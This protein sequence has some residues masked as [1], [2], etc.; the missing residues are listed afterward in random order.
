VRYQDRV[1]L[2]GEEVL[3]HVSPH[4]STIARPVVLLFVVVAVASFG[5][6]ATPPGV[7]QGTVRAV[8]VAVAAGVLLLWVAR[9]LWR[10]RT[11]SFLVTGERLLLRRGF[12]ARCTESV[13]LASVV[14]VTSV[15]SA[16]DRMT[17]AGTLLV[18]CDDGHD[19]LVV[20]AVP[21]C[22]RVRQ[23]VEELV[24]ELVEDLPDPCTTTGPVPGSRPT[25]RL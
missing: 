18:R 6:A 22:E 16:R 19:P 1:L 11:T 10:W 20:P 17:G 13:D 14:A 2:D 5:A 3:V 4:W 15:R 8:V 25:L 9:P 7:H 12:S 24:E 23:L 21:R